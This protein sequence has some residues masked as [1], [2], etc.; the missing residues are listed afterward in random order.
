VFS[1]ELR[2]NVRAEVA[3]RPL[4]PGREAE[5]AVVAAEAVAAE[6]AEAVAAEA[7][8]AVVA[9]AAARQESSR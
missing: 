3:A 9:E 2:K 1:G 4:A 7:E 6:A 5:A 8:V